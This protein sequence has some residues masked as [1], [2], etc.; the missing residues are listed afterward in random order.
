MNE[1]SAKPGETE[2][3]MPSFDA[4]R[5]WENPIVWKNYRSRMRMQALFNFLLVFIISSFMTFTIYG[6]VERFQADTVM[7]ARSA[8]VPLGILQ[9][10]I[11][12]LSATGR[13]TSGIIHERVTDTIEYTRLTPLS[14]LTKV[15]GYLFGL[16]VRE[17]LILLMTMPFM[18]FLLIAGEIPL[19]V[20]IPVYLVFF[21]SAILFHMLGMVLGLVMLEWRLSVVFTIGLVVAINWILPFFSYLG[22]P[23]VEYLTVRPVFFEKIGPFLPVDVLPVTED[24]PQV[25]VD[26]L[27]GVQFYNWEVSTTGFCL[28]LQGLLIFTLGLMV[29]RKWEDDFGHSLSKLYALFFFVSL[30]IF[31][32]GTLWRNLT[33]DISVAGLLPDDS[34]VKSFAFVIPL[35]YCFFSLAVAIWLIYIVTPS[36]EEYRSGLLRSQK[37]QQSAARKL[38]LFEDNAG[39]LLTTALLAIA[40]FVFILIVQIVMA[41]LGPL[42]ETSPSMM[43]MLRM[44]LVAMLVIFYFAVSVEY[45]QIGRFALLFLMVWIVPILLA[46]F[47]AVVFELEEN[48]VYI[49]S[50]SPFTLI[51]LAAQGL[52]D[53]WV[54]IED[55]QSIRNAYIV[56][57]S[58]VLF[59]TAFLGYQLK[60]QKDRTRQLTESRG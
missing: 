8:I 38:S 54:D 48:V 31:C 57:F 2:R 15:I 30:Q 19:S 51:V 17:Y 10:I 33:L 53:D 5:V 43:G 21:S 56:G 39:S 18:I 34:F 13:I 23:F 60:R 28:I 50:G 27:Q 37:L 52:V 45:L 35:I 11:L 26:A 44:P 47:L 25:F 1:I 32:I 40:T 7:A 16:P 12:M 22:F 58:F 3:L 41:E 59:V 55:I 20:V 42:R 29:Y 24:V 6:G 36:H 49:A 14:P 4:W 46:I 9:W